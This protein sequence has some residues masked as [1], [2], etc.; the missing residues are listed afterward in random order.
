MSGLGE[1]NMRGINGRAK[2][3][4]MVDVF[5]RESFSSLPSV[6]RKSKGLGSFLGVG[7]LASG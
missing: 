3:E 6:R 5:D 4:D 1:W 7:Y 2:K